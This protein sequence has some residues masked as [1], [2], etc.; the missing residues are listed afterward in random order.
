MNETEKA[1]M[2]NIHKV[3]QLT[4]AE[5][6]EYISSLETLTTARTNQLKEALLRNDAVYEGLKQVQAAD[7]FDTMR[8]LVGDLIA[9]MDHGRHEGQNFA[10]RKRLF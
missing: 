10:Y 8:S 6:D 5:K 9:K 7:S 3:D 2:Q 4:E 1:M